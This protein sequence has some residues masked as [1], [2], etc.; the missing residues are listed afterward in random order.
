V[1]HAQAMHS[2]IPSSRLVVYEDARHHV[3]LTHA[4]ACAWEMLNFLHNLHRD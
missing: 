3:F 4:E 1:E 2:T